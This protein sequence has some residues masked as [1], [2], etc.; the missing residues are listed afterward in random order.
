M[1]Y[2]VFGA[3]RSLVDA[4][5]ERRL[6]TYGEL[7]GKFGGS[8]LGWCGPLNRLAIRMRAD[9]WPLLSVLVV[10]RGKDIP[11][12]DI[13]RVFGMTDAQSLRDEQQ[14]CFDHDW[15]TLAR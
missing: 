3:D 8:P 10:P 7:A 9:G 4:A 5:R 12:A 15:S 11:N 2:D 1:A 6:V 14:R 13:Y